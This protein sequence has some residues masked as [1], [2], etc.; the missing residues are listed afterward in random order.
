MRLSIFENVEYVFGLVL[1]NRI[2]SFQDETETFA[3][4]IDEYINQNHKKLQQR[5]TF[6]IR[7]CV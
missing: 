5:I 1:L 7:A 6:V 2:R 4:N 3:I